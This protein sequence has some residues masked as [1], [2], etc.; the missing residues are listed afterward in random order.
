MLRGGAGQSALEALDAASAGGACRPSGVRRVAVEARVDRQV[1]GCPARLDLGAARRTS[2]DGRF[3]DGM[4]PCL[5]ASPYSLF[6][7]GN[8]PISRDIPSEICK[9]L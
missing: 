1:A 5:H 8:A 6:R 4:D 3:M 9:K 2:D 7:D